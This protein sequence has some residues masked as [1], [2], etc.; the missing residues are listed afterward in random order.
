M[1]VWMSETLSYKAVY[2]AEY[3]EFGALMDRQTLLLWDDTLQS[4]INSTR[5]CVNTH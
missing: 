4:L 5:F 1:S 3:K 2:F